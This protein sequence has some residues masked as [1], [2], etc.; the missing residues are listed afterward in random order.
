MDVAGGTMEE[1]RTA[2]AKA[3][4]TLGTAARK[5]FW[6]PISKHF[7]RPS[8]WA[9]KHYQSAIRKYAFEDQLTDEDKE[10]MSK[11]IRGMGP[12]A[13]PGD[14][15]KEAAKVLEG[16]NICPKKYQDFV[17]QELKRVRENRHFI[18]RPATPWYYPYIYAGSIP[19]GADPC[20]R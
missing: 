3:Y 13:Q 16:R 1:L 14:A 5:N 15:V 2:C 17:Y 19:H 8:Y 11:V 12:N 7:N 6:A 10:K 18:P 4:E 9:S 20:S